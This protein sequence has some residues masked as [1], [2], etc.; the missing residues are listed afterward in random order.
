MKSTNEKQSYLKL[1]FSLISLLLM[2]PLL[3]TGDEN[4]YRTLFI[5]LINRV[6]DMVYATKHNES[7]FFV[8]WGLINQWMSIIVCALA[9]CSITPAFREIL[10]NT[11]KWVNLALFACAILCVAKEMLILI[12]DSIYEKLINDKLTK[13]VNGMKGE[14]L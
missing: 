6:I 14:C 2:I 10:L 3:I 12:I 8:I 4:Y 7:I 13:D 9:F 11:S 1:I 5:F